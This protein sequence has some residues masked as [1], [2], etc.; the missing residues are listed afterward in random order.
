MDWPIAVHFYNTLHVL[1]NTCNAKIPGVDLI[2]AIASVASCTDSKEINDTS[3][4]IS[5]IEEIR[6]CDHVFTGQELFP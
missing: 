4:M 1:Q 3:P 2:L 6:M 5:Q